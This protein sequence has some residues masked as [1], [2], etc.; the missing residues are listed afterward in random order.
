MATNYFISDLH[1]G[2]KR[3]LDFAGKYRDFGDTVDEHDYTLISRIASVARKKTDIL[4]ILGDVAMYEEKLTLLDQLQCRKVLIRGNH[5]NF[6]DHI[7]H[8]YFERI[9]GLC[10]FK[11]RLWLSHAP[12]HPDELRGCINIHGHVHYKSIMNNENKKFDVRYV[13]VCVENCNGYPIAYEDIKD[14]T[15]KGVIS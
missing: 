6:K 8:K 9:E 7:Y 11:R 5:D 10:K 3:I 14:G 2:H 12:I 13:N 1:L 4:Y 15:F